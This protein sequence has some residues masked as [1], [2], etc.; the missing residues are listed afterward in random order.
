MRIMG[1]SENTK[2][3]RQIKDISKSINTGIKK[4]NIYIGKDI[5]KEAR[6]TIKEDSKTGKYH[7]LRDVWTGQVRIH[8]ASAPNETPA[9]F[10]GSLAASI[11]YVPSN[12]ELIIGAGGS[13]PSVNTESGQ[14]GFGVFVD[15]AA[16]LEKSGRRYLKPS[17]QKKQKDTEN[18]YYQETRRELLK[19]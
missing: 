11:G 7:I 13:S 6:R 8:R 5:V 12:N 2:V 1:V 15:Y 19:K 14:I 16:K 18:Y 3:F 9:N 17:I 4:A 10:S